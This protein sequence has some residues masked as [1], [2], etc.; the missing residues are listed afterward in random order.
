MSIS[1]PP[2]SARDGQLITPFHTILN[3]LVGSCQ[4]ALAAGIVD[5]LGESVDVASVDVSAAAGLAPSMPAYLIKL[6]GAHWQLVMRDAAATEA[7][8]GVRQMW[9]WADGYSYISVWLPDGYVLTLVCRPDGLSQV[10]HRAIRQAEV[11]LCVEAG[12]RVPQPDQIC[13][14][15]VGVQLD[16]QGEPAAVEL[17]G[18]WQ[19]GLRSLGR[20][21]ALTKLEKGFQVLTPTGQELRLVRE[22]TG[23]WFAGTSLRALEH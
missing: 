4:A 7:L 21:T 15:R 3:R 16:P 8:G 2:M 13:W 20:A 19:A 11:E 12:W 14:R 18:R 5:E 17:Q 9:V 23:Y 22:P 1:A 6:S 10:S